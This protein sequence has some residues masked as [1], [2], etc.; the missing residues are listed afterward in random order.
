MANSV[1]LT[2]LTPREAVADALYRCV[3]GIDTND[4]E[5]FE[6]A[7]LKNESMTFVA[8]PVNIEGWT[9]VNELTQKAFAVVTTHIISN[10]RIEL[11]DG[12]DTASMTAHAISYHVRPEDTLKPEDTSYT[13][14]SLYN[15]GLARDG[16]DGLWKIKKWEVKIL[17]TTGDKA[18]LHG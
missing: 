1:N 12:A 9:A 8:G 13:A 4:Q 11:K 7:C 3:L 17:W 10:I 2:A 14:G 18:V 15:L 6:S 5:L 16:D